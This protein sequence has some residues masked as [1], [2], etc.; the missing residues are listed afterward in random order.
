[1]STPHPPTRSSD[2]ARIRK[3]FRAPR[4]WYGVA[5]AAEILRMQPP[6]VREAIAEGSIDAVD[7]EGQIRIPWEEVVTLGLLVRW[8]PRMVSRALPAAD[9]PPLAR[10]VRGRVELPQYL[11]DRLALLA[12]E[13][14]RAEEREIT[15]SDVL[16]EVVHH[17]L[18]VQTIWP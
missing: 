7:H 10:S 17:A 9:V 3:L 18:D 5:E 14:A 11:W 2:R 12:E 8:T 4:P 13:R 15:V 1:M 16:E 6:A